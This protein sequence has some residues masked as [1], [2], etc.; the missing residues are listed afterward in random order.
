M[1]NYSPL[2][3]KLVI[4]PIP[5]EEKIGSIYIA[6]STRPKPQRGTVLAVGEGSW[7]SIAGKCRRLAVSVGQIV[8]FGKYAGQQ[9]TVNNEDVLILREEELLAIEHPVDVATE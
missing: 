2:Y 5:S 6:E 3:D 9:I 7:D 1:V 8:L 4:R